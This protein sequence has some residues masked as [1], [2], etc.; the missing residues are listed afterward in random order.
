MFHAPAAS[1]GPGRVAVE[2]LAGFLAGL[3]GWVAMAG[4]QTPS[5]LNEWQ[6]SAGVQLQRMLD[7]DLP[8]WQSYVGVA[9]SLQPLYDGARPY[10]VAPFPVI[11]VRYRDL[12]FVSTSEGV[13]VNLLRGAHWRAGIAA[14][15]DLGRDEDD[16]PSRLR[17]TGDIRPAPEAKLFAEYV[18]SP[19]FPLV[20]RA[21]VRRALGGS[22]GW[23]GDLGAY[24]PL[25]GSSERFV[26]FAGASLTFADSRYM[27][28]W[29]G[30][31]EAQSVR[32]GYRRHEASAGLRS[33]GFGA[34]AVWV[35]GTHWLFGANLAIAQLTGT[36]ADSPL[37][38]R[39][40][41]TALAL[42]A[43]YRF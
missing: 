36:A 14:T 2:R 9:A 42:S 13:G 17:G 27:D 39:T 3:L 30:V 6:Y 26:W 34:S 18:L 35:T 21:N 10:H 12:A 1:A 31:G 23:I 25:P 38:E 41:N 7:P 20:L 32:S 24:L 4:A 43:L 37:T 15:Y 40:T 16:Y 11:D 19:D 8:T 22:D 5:P 29:F 33:V 28:R